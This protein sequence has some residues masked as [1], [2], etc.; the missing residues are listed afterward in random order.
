[1]TPI[2]AAKRMQGGEENHVANSCS[3]PNCQIYAR[4]CA[5]RLAEQRPTLDDVVTE[6]DT[7]VT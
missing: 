2:L 6:V 1:M 5:A 3:P 4:E 7:I